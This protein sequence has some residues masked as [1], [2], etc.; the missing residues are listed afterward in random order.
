MGFFDLPDREIINRTNVSALDN[1]ATLKNNSV[2]CQPA[3]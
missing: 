1:E 2:S 3:G